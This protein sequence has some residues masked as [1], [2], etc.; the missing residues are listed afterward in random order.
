MMIVPRLWLV[1]LA[2]AFAAAAY[3]S[4][5]DWALTNMPRIEALGA[6]DEGP[7]VNQLLGRS[8]L[9][10]GLLPYTARQRGNRALEPTAAPARPQVG[11]SYRELSIL[12]MPIWAYED[13]GLVAY[14]EERDGYYYVPLDEEQSAALDRI[15]GSRHSDYR[16]PFWE[17]LWGWLLLV[18]L[19]VWTFLHLRAGAKLEEQAEFAEAEGASA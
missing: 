5:R 18:G 9:E 15:T 12:R 6:L 1:F 14:S 13:Q 3:F 11:F 16:F 7:E 8:Q 2:V 10:P 19:I 4:D 17:H